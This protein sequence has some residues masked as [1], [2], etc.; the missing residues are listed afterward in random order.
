MPGVTA[1][2]GQGPSCPLGTETRVEPPSSSGGPSL[3][4]WCYF[5]AQV[6]STRTAWRSELVLLVP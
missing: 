5:Q 4:L 1:Q 2:A 6:G 3:H